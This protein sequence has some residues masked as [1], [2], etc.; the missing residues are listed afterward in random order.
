MFGKLQCEGK[1]VGR[2]IPAEGAWL[3]FA[4]ALF[5]QADLAPA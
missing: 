1:L 3:F 4:V 2:G 5:I